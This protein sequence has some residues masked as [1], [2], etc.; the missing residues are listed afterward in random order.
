MSP[1]RTFCSFIRTCA[2][3]RAILMWV[4]SR[5]FISWPSSSMMTPLRTSP[6]LIM[7]VVA[8]RRWWSCGA[9]QVRLGDVGVLL[10]LRLGEV[11]GAVALAV[12]TGGHEEE[13]ARCR[14]GVGHRGDGRDARR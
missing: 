14:V 7:P 13:I 9:L 2:E 6:V 12:G 3:P 11:V 8:S 5:T 1:L 4:Q 10:R